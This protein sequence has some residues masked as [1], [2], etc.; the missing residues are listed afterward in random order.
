MKVVRTEAVA[1]DELEPRVHAHEMALIE[2]AAFLE[3]NHIL[4]W[5]LKLSRRA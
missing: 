1:M 2:V 3:R 4:S 5:A